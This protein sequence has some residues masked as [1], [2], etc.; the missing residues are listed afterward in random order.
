[1]A[2]VEAFLTLADELH[3]GRTA[4]RLYVS[5]PRVSRLIASLERLA[6]G[7]L[8][9]RTNRKVTLTP[10]GRQLHSRLRPAYD[11]MAAAIE[12]A[13]STSRGVTGLL[14]VGCA[15]TVVGPETAG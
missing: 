1:M 3:F 7:Q 10:L 13:R 15:D 2:Q 8:F 5:Q 11:Q 4:E 9:E 6:G 14:R 12:E